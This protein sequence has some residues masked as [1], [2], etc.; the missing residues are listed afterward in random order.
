MTATI[1]GPL[2]MFPSDI[3]VG[4]AKITLHAD[5]KW[6]GDPVAFVEALK[7]AKQM[8]DPFTMPM[9]WLIAN[10]IGKTG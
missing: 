4:D 2:P 10:A 7:R 9:L 6:S 5:G 1:V 8:S 3:V